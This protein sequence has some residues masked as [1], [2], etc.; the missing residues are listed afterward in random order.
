MLARRVT[1]WVLGVY[2]F[3]QG[4]GLGA[5]RSHPCLAQLEGRDGDWGRLP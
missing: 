1:S 5:P 3:S 2:S 4:S